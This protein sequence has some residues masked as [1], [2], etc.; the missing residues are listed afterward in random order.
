MVYRTFQLSDYA[1]VTR[2][3]N[4]V[5]S[6]SCYEETME[7]FARQLK[8]DSELVLVAEEDAP[9]AEENNRIVGIMIGTI[10]NNQGYY[11]RIAVDKAFQRQGIG[12]AM[13]ETM[14]HRFVQRN[15]SRILVSVDSHNE[16]LLPLYESMGYG[17]TDFLRAFN[18]L[19][20]VTG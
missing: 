20:I 9:V 17:N 8:W 6:E 7:A 15:V 10:D 4:E 5:L 2:L 18:R 14:K 13:I 12:K 1:P 11:Y 3:L 16:P 19:S